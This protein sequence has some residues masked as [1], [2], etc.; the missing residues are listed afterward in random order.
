M[1]HILLIVDG[2]IALQFLRDVLKSYYSNN[3]YIVIYQDSIFLPKEIP[4]SFEFYHCD[5]T[6]SFRLNNLLANKD[7]SDAFIVLKDPNEA[8]VIYEY[9]RS[10]Y[11]KIRIIKSIYDSNKKYQ[12]LMNKDSNLICISQTEAMSLKLLSRLPN[13]PVVPRG[14]GLEQG[15][16]MEIGVPSGSVFAHRQV[17]TIQQINWRIIGIYR[18]QNFMLATSQS[19]IMPGDTLLV[20]GNPNVMHTIYQRI[21]SEMGQFPLPFGMEMYLFLD[22]SL[23]SKDQMLFDC[24]EAIYLHRHLKSIHLTIK[25]LHPT[26]FKTIREIDSLSQNDISIIVDYNSQDFIQT[27]RNKFG[28]KIGLIVVG[29]ELFS[30][31]NYRKVLWQSKIP[32]FKTAKS[33]I[34]AKDYNPNIEKSKLQNN[35][36]KLC[37]PPAVSESLIVI[38]S[39][40]YKDYNISTVIFDISKQLQL[41][42]KIY[43]FEPDNHFSNEVTEHFSNISRIFERKF[44]IERTNSHNPILYLQNLKEP[45]L[46]FVPFRASITKSRILAFTKVQFESLSFM[47]DMN[48]QIF[49]P[50]AE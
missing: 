43:D 42:V 27:V 21:K 14:F 22:M 35:N 1:K 25:I 10:N 30:K 11:K 46:Q 40:S 20:A 5:Y 28:K 29:N 6:S 4:S 17:N 3:L 32:V 36:N 41:N 48:P 16:V 45:V 34:S 26:N 24:R 2:E 37:Y 33:A 19:I 9:L 47:V 49:I 39:D 50:I 38:T 15:E 18:R 44:F 31:R 12:E 8:H 23:Q 13:V 7:I